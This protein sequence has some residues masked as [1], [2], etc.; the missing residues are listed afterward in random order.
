MEQLIKEYENKVIES[1]RKTL[2]TE[3]AFFLEKYKLLAS[4]NLTVPTTSLSKKI[5]KEDGNCECEFPINETEI[6]AK[7]ASDIISKNEAESKNL[8]VPTTSLSKEH[9]L[10]INDVLTTPSYN[11]TVP[12]TSL[13]KKEHELPIND[14]LI[15]PSKNLTVPETISKKIIKEE[16]HREREFPIKSPESLTCQYVIGLGKNKGN[17]CPLKRNGDM[18]CTKHLKMKLKNDEDDGLTEIKKLPSV[19]KLRLNPRQ[20]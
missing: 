17:T 3:R 19:R 18:Y 16:G 1:I 15:T 11:L 8:T 9:E 2:D 14:V 20:N 7:I 13:S 4:K 10:L 6:V 5:I 12:E